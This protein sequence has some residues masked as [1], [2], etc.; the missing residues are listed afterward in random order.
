GEDAVDYDR[1]LFITDANDGG[2]DNDYIQFDKQTLLV[3]RDK[4]IENF[5]TVQFSVY[6]DSVIFADGNVASGS[7]LVVYA[8]YGEDYID[9]SRETNGPFELFGSCGEDTLIGGA[10]NDP[11]DGG[12]GEDLLTGGA[13]ADQFVHDLNWNNGFNYFDVIQD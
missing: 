11:V 8:N 6:S 10:K 5:E 12:E 13:G 1:G 3:L 7:N 2:A 4:S 9:G